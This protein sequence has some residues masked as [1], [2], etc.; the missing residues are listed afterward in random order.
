VAVGVLVGA[1]T[2]LAFGALRADDGTA[3]SHTVAEL[4]IEPSMTSGPRGVGLLRHRSGQ[5]SVV[6]WG[7]SRARGTPCTSTARTARAAGSGPGGRSPRPRGERRRRGDRPDRHHP[8]RATSCSR[9]STTTSTPSRPPSATTPRSPAA[10][11]TP[12]QVADVL[13]GVPGG[14]L[15]TCNALSR[16]SS[17]AFGTS[18]SCARRRSVSLSIEVRARLKTRRSEGRQAG[19]KRAV[20]ETGD[21]GSIPAASTLAYQAG[22]S[23]IGIVRA[24]RCPARRFFVE[25]VHIPLNRRGSNHCGLRLYRLLDRPCRSSR[26]PL[27]ELVG[28]AAQ[29]PP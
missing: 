20:D 1:S 4:E 13:S 12:V 3:D 29:P 16:A 26:P 11:C 17:S 28:G 6:V 8:P 7:W 10:T 23:S 22:Y 9:A 2:S 25:V 15:R 5:L 24:D 19:G 18:P 21:A 27:A 14:D